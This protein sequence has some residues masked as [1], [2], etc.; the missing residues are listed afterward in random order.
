VRWVTVGPWEGAVWVAVCGLDIVASFVL[1]D[2]EA[3]ARFLVELAYPVVPTLC[4]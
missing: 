4:Q 2:L 1:V 3:L